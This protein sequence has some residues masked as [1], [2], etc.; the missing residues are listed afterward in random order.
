[1]AAAPQHVVALNGFLALPMP[2]STPVAILGFSS[3]DR[4]ALAASLARTERRTPAYTTVLSIEDARCVIA[5]ADHPEVMAL[6]QALGRVGD[7]VKLFAAV[8]KKFP[9]QEWEVLQ[10][11]KSAADLLW[12]A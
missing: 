2:A 10:S 5:D 1:M 3:T 12:D 8:E 11:W 6:L 4:L 9:D 7:A